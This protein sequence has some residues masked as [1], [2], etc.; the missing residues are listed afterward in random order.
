[1]NLMLY[2]EGLKTYFILNQSIK[3]ATKLHF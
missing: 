2:K 1:M 3:S